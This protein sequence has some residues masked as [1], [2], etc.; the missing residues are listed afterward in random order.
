MW[1]QI[2]LISFTIITFFIHLLGMMKVISVYISSILL[3]SSF[4]LLLTCLN[5][6]K[7]PQLRHFIHAQTEKEK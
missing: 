5:E 6:R 2:I 4:V 1:K 3:F 7:P